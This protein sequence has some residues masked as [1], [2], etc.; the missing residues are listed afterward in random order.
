MFWQENDESGK[1]VVPDDIQDLAFSLDCRWLPVDHAEAL[2]NAV[3]QALPWL[4]EESQAGIHQIHVA[5]SGNGWFRP[6]PG[7]DQM[8]CLSRR[9]KLS[10]RLPKRRLDDAQALVGQT[11]DVAGQAMTIGKARLKPLVNSAT[12][13]CR[14]LVGKPDE[15]EARFLERAVNALR[16]I[17]IPAR[18][19]LC[20]REHV[21]ATEH[22]PLITR[23]LML[24]DLS[25]EES[26]RLQEHGLGEHKLIGCGLFLPH[27]GIDAVKKPNDDQN[28]GR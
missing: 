24:A 18:K 16:S 6:E 9:T 12:T 25:P 3:L 23:S 20:G 17:D 5:E 8:L 10:L 26:I 4:R 13:F 1:F 19:A 15:S 7:S 11:L 28:T 21:I 27:K 22:G 2:S 14:Y